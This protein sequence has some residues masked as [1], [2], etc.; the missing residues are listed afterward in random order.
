MENLQEIGSEGRN[1]LKVVVI[2]TARWMSI[3]KIKASITFPQA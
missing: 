2:E 1:I 3:G